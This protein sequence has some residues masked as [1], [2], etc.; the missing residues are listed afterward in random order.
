MSCQI[1]KR[2][3][4]S[5][6][7]LG[8]TCSYKYLPVNVKATLL[9]AFD[10]VKRL[11]PFHEN[12]TAQTIVL[13]ENI[14]LYLTDNERENILLRLQTAFPYVQFICSTN[15]KI[16]VNSLTANNQIIKYY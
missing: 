3:L 15:S 11:Y 16:I 9:L 2:S 14:E 13:I 5:F 6:T 1:L 8:I 10:I 7:R 12:E 4:M